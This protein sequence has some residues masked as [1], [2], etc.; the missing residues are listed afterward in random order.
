MFADFVSPSGLMGRDPAYP[1]AYA[2]ST[3]YAALRAP[4]LSKK[5][6]VLTYASSF[7]YGNI[8]RTSRTLFQE[9]F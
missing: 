1:S 5:C 4:D 7:L 3:T 9:S 2:D 6:N 8:F